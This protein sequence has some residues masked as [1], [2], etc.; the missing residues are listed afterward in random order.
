MPRTKAPGESLSAKLKRLFRADTE[1]LRTRDY[2]GLKAAWEKGNPGKPFSEKL[3]QI[4][5]NIKSRLRKELGM[6][7]RG[8]KRKMHASANGVAGPKPVR[9]ALL[10]PLEEHVDECLML[11]RGVGR[12][13]LGDVIRYLK[14]ARNLLIVMIGDQ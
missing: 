1:L 9:P 8:R 6:R 5:A 4:A 11:A 2:D 7:K 3:R 12:E 13:Q 14:R 10:V